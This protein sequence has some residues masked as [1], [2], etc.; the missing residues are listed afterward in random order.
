LLDAL[1]RALSVHVQREKKA[2]VAPTLDPDLARRLPLRLLL[3]DDN[4]INQKVT[5]SVLHKLGYRA[6]IANN[7]L[8][9]LKALEQ[10]AYDILFL[11]VQMPEMDGLEA[12]R[13]ICQRWPTEKRPCI[14]A[15]TG[16]A[17]TGDREKCLSAGMDDYI[18]KPVRVGDLQSALRRWGPVKTRKSDTA[19]ASRLKPAAADN[20]LDQATIAELR[21][22]PA[23]DGVSMLQELVDLFLEAAPQR[24]AQ[25]SE[26]INDGPM[27]AFHAHAL[28][29]I[30]LNLGVKRIVELSQKL[31]DLG[32]TRNVHAAPAMLQ[33]LETAFAQTQ[34]QLL[35]LHSQ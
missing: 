24:I 25:I 10:K 17:L 21:N 26:S 12:A 7:G 2:P 28:K 23:S 19:F 34:A 14:I 22:Q 16:N 35:M 32:R 27:L 33:E 4:P 30:G 5:L 1:C 31:E 15:M 3:A 20:L 29:S 9:V 13:H 8:E 18:S 6:D 11:D